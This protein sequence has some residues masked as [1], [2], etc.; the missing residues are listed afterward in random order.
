MKQENATLQQAIGRDKTSK[1]KV[2]K[3]LTK[4]YSDLA[5]ASKNVETL[6]LE[7]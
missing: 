6:N 2:E 4:V 1:E 3:E 7:K 5:V